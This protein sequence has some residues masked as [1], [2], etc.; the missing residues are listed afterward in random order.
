M[1]ETNV[2]KY[3]RS[4][5]REIILAKGEIRID[6]NWH[7]CRVLNISAGGAKLQVDRRIDIGLTEFLRIGK[8]DHIKTTVVWRQRNEIG[9]A[10][11]HDALAIADALVKLAS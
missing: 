4:N 10:F 11:S 7:I 3:Q 1:F 5:S 8:Y 2:I 9:V 6:G